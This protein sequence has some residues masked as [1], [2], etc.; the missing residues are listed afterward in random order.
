MK[1]SILK[2]RDLKYSSGN[3][4]ME[5]DIPFIIPD[6]DAISEDNDDECHYECEELHAPIDDHNELTITRGGR[7]RKRQTWM[8]R[9]E[10]VLNRVTVQWKMEILVCWYLC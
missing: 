10:F 9:V 6:M 8:V 3:E 4:E 7:R 1:W 2:F 5:N